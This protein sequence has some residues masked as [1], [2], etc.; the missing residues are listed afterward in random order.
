MPSVR[1]LLEAKKRDRPDLSEVQIGMVGCRAM[2]CFY[3]VSVGPKNLMC[4]QCIGTMKIQD[5]RARGSHEAS[6][7]TREAV[8]EKKLANPRGLKCEDCDKRAELYDHRDYNK[9]LKVAP[10][11]FGCNKRRGSALPI[12]GYEPSETMRLF[13]EGKIK[14]I[15]YD[16]PPFKGELLK[17]MRESKNKTLA[18]VSEKIGRDES[19]ISTWENGKRTPSPRSMRALSEF[20]KV[21]ISTFFLLMVLISS[22]HAAD[23]D[24]VAAAH[25]G[26][27]ETIADNTGPWVERYTGGQRVPWCAGFVSYVLREAGHDLPYTLWAR[28]FAKRGAYGKVAAGPASGEIVVFKR[29]KASGHVAIVDQVI[30]QNRFWIIEGNSGSFPAKVKR[31]FVDRTKDYGREVIAFVKV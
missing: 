9:P 28:D 29:G 16:R 8:E 24:K 18:E 26:R 10:V 6:K 30:D 31:S 20:F 22:A 25:I 7:I 19:A 11:C 1:T 23:L 4:G 3:C 13:A 5:A 12:K 2:T 21:P 15:S 27:G 17:S 14:R